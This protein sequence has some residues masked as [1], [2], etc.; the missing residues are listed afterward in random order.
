MQDTNFAHA[1]R[2]LPVCIL[3]LPLRNYSLS[4][5][6]FLLREKNAFLLKSPADFAVMSVASQIFALNRAV[7]ICSNTHSQN[8]SEH[9]IRLK[10]WIIEFRNRRLSGPDYAI[11][12]TKMWQYLSLGR[13]CPRL[14]KRVLEA[15]DKSG[16]PFGA[17]LLGQLHHFVLT[18]PE[19]QK[20]ESAHQMLDVVWN[21][22]FSESIW[23]YFVSLELEGAVQIENEDEQTTR[24]TREKIESDY[25]AAVADW[26]SCTTDAERIAALEKTPL[27]RKLAALEAEVAAF[28]NRKESRCQV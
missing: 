16:R 24:V 12:I 22:S 19:V 26:K 20:F 13:G 18:L 28:D 3:K 4:H 27:I 25:K 9:F 2:P 15:G 21:F 11:E 17:P 10:S 1:I 7:W 14:S 8:E 23:R 5:E 6:L